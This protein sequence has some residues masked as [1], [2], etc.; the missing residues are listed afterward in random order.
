MKALKKSFL[1]VFSASFVVLLFVVS[2]VVSA[3]DFYQIKVYTIKDGTQESVIDTYLKDAYLPALHRVGVKKVGVFKPIADDPAAG[4]KIFVFIPLKD[5]NQV[6]KIEEDLLKDKKY[7]KK[8]EAYINA[9]HDNAPYERIESILLA[10]FSAQPVFYAPEFSTPKSEQI[11]ELRSYEGATEKLYQ[12]K[13]EMF[14]GGG[15]AAIFQNIG[16]NPVF[17]GEVLSGSK[18]PNLMYMTS[19]E[20]MESNK[21]HWKTFVDSPEW[22]ELKVKPEYANT[23]SHIDK[24]LMYP[25]D[26]SEF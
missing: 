15:E 26:Y 12:K 13:V 14:N 2:N 17:F 9:A 25:T 7:L 18:M 4:T 21:A 10:A 22:K 23:V 6:V 11:F 1:R 19:Y 8:G 5:L 24:W 3:R 16:S 20:N